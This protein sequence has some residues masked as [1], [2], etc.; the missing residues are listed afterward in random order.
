MDVDKYDITVMSIWDHGV[1]KK[2][3][4]TDIKY[5]SIFPNIKGISRIFHPFIEKSSGKLLYHF[6][7]REEY[8][9]EIAFISSFFKYSTL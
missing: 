4:R 5:K 9:F 1:R 2:D 3:L 7:I 6:A 8:D